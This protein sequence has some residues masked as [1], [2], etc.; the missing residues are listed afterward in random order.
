[1]LVD[2]KIKVPL[3]RFFILKYLKWIAD[4]HGEIE[5]EF[6]PSYEGVMVAP[7]IDEGIF[8]KYPGLQTAINAYNNAA[9]GTDDDNIP[10]DLGFYHLNQKMK[11]RFVIT[12][13]ATPG[14]ET[15]TITTADAIQT[16][17]AE[18]HIVTNPKLRLTTFQLKD[19]CAQQLQDMYSQTPLLYPIQFVQWKDFTGSG[20]PKQTESETF[21][22][23]CVPSLINVDAVYLL[24]REHDVISKQRYVNP[25][26]NWRLQIDGSYFPSEEYC[27]IGDLRNTTQTFDAFNINNSPFSSIATD[28]QSSMERFS[29]DTEYHPDA[30]GEKYG[31]KLGTSQYNWTMGDQGNFFTGIPFSE[32]CM[33]QA[34]LTSVDNQVEIE[35]NRS[36]LE[37]PPKL[38]E[39]RYPPPVILGMSDRI[40]KI[41]SRSVPG[42]KRWE[43]I[44]ATVDELARASGIV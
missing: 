33:F 5:I 43:V 42:E 31:G 12:E 15:V 3:N 34:G 16:W 38:K 20:I 6:S 28:V 22:P 35:G 21:Q 41:R 8:N 26:I 24:Y 18:N 2:L 27:S 37:C 29:V 14:A 4:W 44:Q 7:V 1:M 13:G 10:F 17:K 30:A 19:N 25:C 40:L 32:S 36:K 23:S 9:P 11:N 39:I